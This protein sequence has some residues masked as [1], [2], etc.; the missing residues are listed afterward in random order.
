MGKAKR[1]LRRDK[2]AIEKKVDQ[3][4]VTRKKLNALRNQ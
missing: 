2:R 4:Q 1:I 3:K